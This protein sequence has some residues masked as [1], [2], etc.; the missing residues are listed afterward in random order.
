MI[1]APP[2]PVPGFA[3]QATRR[4]SSARLACR[5]L[6]DGLPMNSEFVPNTAFKVSLGQTADFDLGGMRVMPARRQVRF[7]E[8][9]RTLEPR[10]MQVLVALAETRPDVLSRDQ[11]ALACWGGLNI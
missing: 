6:S 4:A 2:A 5:Y 1:R 7:R 3:Y 11:L 8:E 9:T 10:V